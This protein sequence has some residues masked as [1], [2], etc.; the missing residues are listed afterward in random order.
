MQKIKSIYPYAVINVINTCIGGENS[1]QGAKRFDDEVL[2]HQP[3]VLF[4]NYALNDRGVGLEKSYSA[5]SEMIK[6]AKSRNIKV[7]L[8][9][10]S[11]DQ[12]VDYQK[13]FLVSRQSRENVILCT[14][15][16]FHAKSLNPE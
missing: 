10:P 3:N 4:I 7:S 2:S 16:P 1:V 5:W 12:S 13:W 14:L 11:P 6:K 8:I 9:T 15:R